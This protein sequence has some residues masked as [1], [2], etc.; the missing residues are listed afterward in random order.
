MCVP[1]VLLCVFQPESSAAIN[2][3]SLWPNPALR[4]RCAHCLKPMDLPIELIEF[5]NSALYAVSVF[6]NAPL[7]PWGLASQALTC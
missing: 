5:V 7:L 3:S 1:N 6:A 4:K 2:R